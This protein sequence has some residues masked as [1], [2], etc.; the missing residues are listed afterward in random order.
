[1]SEG[2]VLQRNEIPEKYTWN[3]P[4]VFPSEL[5]WEQALESLT[6]DIGTLSQYQGRLSEG[7]KVITEL[8]NLLSD[9]RQRFGRIFTY[10]HFIS[11]LLKIPC[12]LKIMRL[13][14]LQFRLSE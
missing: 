2:R 5:A 7:A 1:M 14:S 8:M 9:L 3:A 12:V 11:L 13:N 4:S 10:I 6:N